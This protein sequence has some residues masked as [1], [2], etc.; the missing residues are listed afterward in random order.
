M[1]HRHSAFAVAAGDDGAVKVDDD[2]FVADEEDE[3]DDA[4]AAADGDAAMD[5]RDHRAF[6]AAVDDACRHTDG[7]G[8]SAGAFNFYHFPA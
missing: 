1:P 7:A 8:E 2:T 3:H 5:D 4:A 6:A